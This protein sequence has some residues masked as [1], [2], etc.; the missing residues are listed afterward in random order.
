[1]KTNNILLSVIVPT[2]NRYEYL[3]QCITTLASIDNGSIELIIQ[4]NSDDNLE[5]LAFLDTIKYSNMK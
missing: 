5:I 4:D 3:K 2:K 1:M